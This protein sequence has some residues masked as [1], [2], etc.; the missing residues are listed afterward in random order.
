MD[1]CNCS[2][3]IVKLTYSSRN[4]G[5]ASSAFVHILT[6]CGMNWH[7]LKIRTAIAFFK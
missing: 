4:N 1:N 2:C 7:L 5:M 6:Y 3:E